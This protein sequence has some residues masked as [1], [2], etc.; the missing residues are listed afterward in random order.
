MPSLQRR[1]TAQV[2]YGP[3]DIEARAQ[4]LP[5]MGSGRVFPIAEAEITC[6]AFPVPEHWPQIGGLDFGW[7]HPTAAVSLAH[8]RD[9]D[10]VYVTHSY[11]KREATPCSTAKP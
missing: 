4:G 8:D 2:S 6:K 9:A 1:T 10:I 3:A 11:R 5:R 7:D